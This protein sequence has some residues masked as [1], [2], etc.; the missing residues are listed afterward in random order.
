[1]CQ[2]PA[3]SLD[4]A[5]RRRCHFWDT[6]PVP[7]LYELIT[8]HGAMEADKDGVCQE[9]CSLPQGDTLDLGNADVLQELC[10]QLSENYVEDK[11]STFRRNYWPEFLLCVKKMVEINFLCVH[12][13]LR[14]KWAG[15][16]WIRETIRRVNPERI[17]QAVYIAAV[18]LPQPMATCR[19]WCRSLH[20]RKLVKVQ[21]PHVSRHLTLQRTTGPC[22]LP[23]NASGKLTDF[24]SF[25]R[26]PSTITLHPA[27]RSLEVASAFDNI[28]TEMPLP[29]LRSDALVT[30]KPVSPPCPISRGTATPASV[31]PG[32]HPLR[33]FHC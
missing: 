32:W 18:V 16:V 13:K 10:P 33:W 29:A 8:S 7:K 14:S 15:P 17:F 4:E 26:L 30:A 23:E 12:K 20:P 6:Q 31:S 5:A 1:M 21:F 19:S 2:G 11:A 22:R 24:L 3:R 25:Y 9:S 28:H 27:L